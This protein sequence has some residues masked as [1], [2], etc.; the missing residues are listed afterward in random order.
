M[1]LVEKFITLINFIVKI[2]L[3]ISRLFHKPIKNNLNQKLKIIPCFLSDNSIKDRVDTILYECGPLYYI[4]DG[5]Q[6][7]VII[8]DY[9]HAKEFYKLKRRRNYDYLGYVYKILF[10]K[11]IYIHDDKEWS[12]L[13]EPLTN[14]FSRESIK[15]HFDMIFEKVDQRIQ[16]NFSQY[17]YYYSIDGFYFD[18][19]F[20][21]ILSNIIYGEMPKKDFE[22][23]YQ[24]YLIHQDLMDI[25]RQDM[26][27]RFNCVNYFFNMPNH[28]HVK[29]FW[30]CWQ[31]FNNMKI[32]TIKKN[33]LLQMIINNNVYKNNLLV[34]H[35]TLYEILLFSVDIMITSFSNLIRDIASDNNVRKSICDEIRSNNIMSF[36]NITSLEYLNNVICESARLNPAISLT[37]PQIITENATL[38]GFNLPAGTQ[39]SLDI[40]MIN[41]DA[42]IWEKP[43]S[44]FPNRFL[45]NKSSNQDPYVLFNR[46]GLSSRKCVGDILADTILKTS[47]IVLL[48]YFNFALIN[49]EIHFIKNR[50]LPIQ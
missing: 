4:F 42:K 8:G 45:K 31:Q 22:E 44:F 30:K 15:S 33:T 26:L 12:L 13:R 9:Y 5:Q 49:G 48:N 32:N 16:E 19:L 24:L 35:H 38:N 29:N 50:L 46:F 7:I 40:Q 14:F 37:F 18:K 21:S 36:D 28:N 43:H 6:R 47:I 27:L 41:R 17:Y 20:L 11:C 10:N 3:V 23:L 2:F 34:F 39:V 25:M 1:T